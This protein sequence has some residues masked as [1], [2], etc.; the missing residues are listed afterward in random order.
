[1]SAE[2]KEPNDSRGMNEEQAESRERNRISDGPAD[3]VSQPAGSNEVQR[4]AATPDPSSVR[5]GGAYPENDK[6]RNPVP[7]GDD[8]SNPVGE[9][10]SSSDPLFPDY[11]SSAL[12][13]VID[14]L[15]LQTHDDSIAGGPDR[16]RYDAE[17]PSPLIDLIRE[18]Q[19]NQIHVSLFQFQKSRPNLVHGPEIDYGGRKHYVPK[20]PPAV[21]GSLLLPRWVADY[22]KTRE[23]FNAIQAL[24]KK[25]LA[26][27][28]R[29]CALLTYWCIA[30]W[31][32]DFLDFIPRLTITGP[33]FAAD[34]L[35]RVLR[36]ICR[37]P[38]LLAG[39]NSAV[40]R[41]IAVGQLMPTLFIRETRLS[42]KTIELLDASDQQGYLVAC[43]KDVCDFY[44]AKCIYVGEYSEAVSVPT[45]IHVHV[46]AR[47]PMSAATV[48][49]D[50]DSQLLQGQLFRYRAFNHD[51]VRLSEFTPSRLSPELSA[52]AEQ[53]G[54]AIVEDEPL[55]DELIEF[56]TEQDEQARVDRSTA[57]NA[58][59]LKAVLFHCHE[60]E[61]QKVFVRDLA[62]TV[63]NT[64]RDEGEP[65]KIS[66]E[67][68]GH[69]LKSLGL[70]TQRLNN[71]GRGLVLDNATRIRAHELSYANEVLPE[72]PACGHC[73]RLHVQQSQ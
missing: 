17:D 49:F 22:G 47:K 42:K 44:C 27:P 3:L 13:K 46:T 20:L 7:V 11:Q 50:A 15:A 10:Y 54:A 43:G 61:Q 8:A 52:V 14:G 51:L 23:L 55:Q 4:N 32:P 19:T 18:S 72:T 48:P 9:S 34:H 65:L 66:N 59:V 60:G 26:L 41:A 62:A 69:V 35:F 29:Q 2:M 30:S 67:R 71:A 73:Q 39:I 31:F 68:L 64:Y 24:L 16:Y 40:F 45:G 12:E 36:C 56:L 38:L 63:N 58:M 25:H 28:E 1:M 21:A 5:D 33:A 70:Y 57:V 37:R 6:E 53:L